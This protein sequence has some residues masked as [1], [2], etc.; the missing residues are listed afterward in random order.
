MC[1]KSRPENTAW[2]AEAIVEKTSI[3][4]T[5]VTYEGERKLERFGDCKERREEKRREEKRR[6]EKRR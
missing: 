4:I 1:M 2:D 5:P 3:T 6:E